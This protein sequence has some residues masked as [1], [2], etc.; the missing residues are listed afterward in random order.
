MIRI[1]EKELSV[2]LQLRMPFD[3]EKSRDEL[4]VYDPGWGKVHIDTVTGMSARLY[5]YVPRN[6]KL[7]GGIQLWFLT[8]RYKL[9][10]GTIFRV[11]PPNLC[12]FKHYAI[13]VIQDEINE[14][15]KELLSEENQEQMNDQTDDEDRPCERTKWLWLLWFYRNLFLIESVLRMVHIVNAYATASGESTLEAILK[16]TDL[17]FDLRASHP[18]D[19]LNMIIQAAWTSGRPLV[20]L[21]EMVT[22]REVVDWITIQPLSE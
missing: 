3:N 9:T 22:L 15:L 14:E 4:Y 12:A 19:W 16:R 5:D 11:L 18:D 1:A 17:L 7:K 13:E 21:R 6:M 10:D 8:P 2:N 20:P